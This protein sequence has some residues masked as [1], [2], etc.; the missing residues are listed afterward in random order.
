MTVVEDRDSN[1]LMTEDTGDMMMIDVADG[2]SDMM[3]DVVDEAAIMIDVVNTTTI[4][5]LVMVVDAVDTTTDVFDNKGYEH[6]SPTVIPF[7][8][9]FV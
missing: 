9:M 8:C 1:I 3:I 4:D 6:S 7:S 5:D 2:H